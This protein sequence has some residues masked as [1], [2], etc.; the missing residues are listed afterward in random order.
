MNKEEQSKDNPETMDLKDLM[1]AMGEHVTEL[2]KRLIVSIIALII[3]VIIG[4]FTAEPVM[5]FLCRP[6]GGLDNLK[7]IEVTENVAAVFKVALLFGFILALPLITYEILAFILP[8]LKSNEKKILFSFLP[9]FI[10]FFLCG[11]AFTYYILLPAAIPFLVSFMGIKTEVRPANYISFSTNL[12]FWV[13]VIFEL[14]L[15]IYMLARIGV[16]TSAMLMKNWRQAIVICTILAAV[17]T[18]TVDPINMT[19][20]MVPLILLFFLSVLFAKVAQS[21]RSRQSKD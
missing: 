14:P 16:L 2:R 4:M 13:G 17:I 11:A 20:L 12:I 6:I 1:E 3:T 19:L 21:A 10:L 5:Q 15:F 8:A 18:P 7:S 9:L